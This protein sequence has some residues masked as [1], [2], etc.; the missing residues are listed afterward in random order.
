MNLLTSTW[1]LFLKYWPVFLEGLIATL[2][3]AAIVVV[4][5]TLVGA[6][7]AMLKQIR[8]KPL[9]LFLTFMINF[10]RGTPLLLQLFFFYLAF[11]S[12]VGFDLSTEFCIILA[13]IV[14]SSAYVAEIFRAGIQAVD[15]GQYEAASSLGMS[16]FHRMT[17][18]ILPQAI[19]NILPALGNEFVMMIK[20]TSL[21]STFFMS[22][23]MT[24]FQV[25]KSN[26][27]LVLE[28]LI[29]IAIIYFTLTTV[30]SSLVKLLETRLS[31][32][33]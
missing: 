29:I 7:L 25:V 26:S 20:E 27:F 1:V 18:I 23:I 2:K 15:S 32:S 9:S 16:E 14:N 31:V 17:R 4:F 24:S 28:P 33:D 21:S 19:K 8:F 10:L 11:P 12:I 22:D 13:L 3:T 6:I 30:F 5:G